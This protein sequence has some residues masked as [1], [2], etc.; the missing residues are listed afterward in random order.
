MATILAPLNNNKRIN[1]LISEETINLSFC[2]TEIQ[3]LNKLTDK[4]FEDLRTTKRWSD[5]LQT[6][7]DIE[8][9][10]IPPQQTFEVVAKYKFEGK[11]QPLDISQFNSDV[12]EEAD[13]NSMPPKRSFTVK[14]NYQ[15]KG[16]GKPLSYST[17]K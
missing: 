17:D 7:K 16:K 11:G 6:P 5:L 4:I 10:P 8:Y 9:N 12:L 15:F 13:Y 1:P 2:S 3:E 14:V